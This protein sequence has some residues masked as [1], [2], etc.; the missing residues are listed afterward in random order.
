MVVSIIVWLLVAAVI[1]WITSILWQHPHGCIMDGAIAVVGMFAGWAIYGAVV[2]TP[3]LL[4]LSFFSLLSGIALAVIALAVARAWRRE[5]EAETE[6]L[7]R[8]EGWEREDA[9][10]RPE[11]PLSEREPE[12]VGEGRLPDERPRDEREEDELPREKPM[13]GTPPQEPMIEHEP[14]DVNQSNRPTDGSPGPE[15]IP[16]QEE[17]ETQRDEETPPPRA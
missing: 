3:Q 6:P 11:K 12:E 9:R 10:P 13:I 2:G 7:E 8:V 4:E 14:G 17:P 5:E 1:A 16:E 15:E